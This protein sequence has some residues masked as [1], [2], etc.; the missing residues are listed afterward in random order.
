ML[1]AHIGCHLVPHPPQTH[2][3]EAVHKCVCVPGHT[4]TPW[5]KG[6]RVS[7]FLE[8]NLGTRKGQRTWASIPGTGA[9]AS[10]ADPGLSRA[11]LTTQSLLRRSKAS[12]GLQRG[13]LARGQMGSPQKVAPQ[14]PH[15]RAG[16]PEPSSPRPRVAG[17]TSQR[18][19]HHS[20][21]GTQHLHRLPHTH[22][23]TKEHTGG[24][25]AAA[26]SPLPTS[27][28]ESPRSAWE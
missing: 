5:G 26:T 6:R 19:R 7:G 12:G 16:N 9:R 15:L 13:V 23:R 24:G 28:T 27:P 3:P 14:R 20:H 25:G 2:P 8:G 17:R 18:P 1:Q 4:C 11:I 22:P 10:P 21:Q